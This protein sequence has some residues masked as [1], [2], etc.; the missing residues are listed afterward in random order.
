MKRSTVVLD[1][2]GV[3]II[4]LAVAALGVA[5]VLW[6]QD[7]L[8]IESI[9]A[10]SVVDLQD[11]QWWPWALLGAG[12]LVALLVLL[13]L[14]R[15]L[16]SSSGRDLALPVTDEPDGTVTVDL[17]AVTKKAAEAARAVD[18]VKS[19]RSRFRRE[20]ISGRRVPVITVIVRAEKGASTA[21]VARDLGDVR[22]A[23]ASVVS[24]DAVGVRVL[25]SGS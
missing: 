13:S 18:G 11:Q 19:A 12:V 6:K 25:L 5:A 2:L 7:R 16:P 15:R 3:L 9:D 23:V 22:S 8:G 10:S 4:G 24:D 1:R 21:T 14:L 20:R 17:R